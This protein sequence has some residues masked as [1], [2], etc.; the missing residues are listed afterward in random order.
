MKFP[1]KSEGY[2]EENK[3]KLEFQVW[4]KDLLSSNDFIASDSINVW[5]VISACIAN[6]NKALYNNKEDFEITLKTRADLNKGKPP[7]LRA[8]VECLTKLEYLLL[9]AE[10]TYCLPGSGEVIRTKIRI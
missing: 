8:S 1:I 4:D 3:F 5:P 2:V 6:G 9:T 7:V 10:L